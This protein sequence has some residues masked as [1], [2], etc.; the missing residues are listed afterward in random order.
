MSGQRAAD[1]V[2]ADLGPLL[3]RVKIFT[4]DEAV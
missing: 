3:K 4:A 1:P 2:A